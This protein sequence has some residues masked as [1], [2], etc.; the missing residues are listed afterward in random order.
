[1]CNDTKADVERLELVLRDALELRVA[2]RS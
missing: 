1:M 2:D